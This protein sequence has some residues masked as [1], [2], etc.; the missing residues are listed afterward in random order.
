MTRLLFLKLL[1]LLR[2]FAYWATVR[3]VDLRLAL[4]NS[5][6]F[7]LTKSKN[8]K[9]TLQWAAAGGEQQAVTPQK[10]IFYGTKRCPSCHNY[11]ACRAGLF[12]PAGGELV[13]SINCMGN[14][15]AEADDQ[16]EE[17]AP[18]EVIEEGEQ[19]DQGEQDQQVEGDEG[20]PS[21]RG[22]TS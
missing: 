20:E 12:V 10:M 3:G 16:S 7:P 14:I 8:T 2:Q 15:V 1:S 11:V 13:T 4:F 5:M 17:A 19:D 6:A 22:R 9:I 21:K 18:E